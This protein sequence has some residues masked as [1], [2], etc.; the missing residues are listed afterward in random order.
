M[1]KQAQSVDES[2]V[3]LSEHVP[4]EEVAQRV[5]DSQED[6]F[7]GTLPLDL[8]WRI[9][10]DNALSYHDKW[11]LARSCKLFHSLVRDDLV[12]KSDAYSYG[13]IPFGLLEASIFKSYKPNLA[14]LCDFFQSRPGLV[15]T[16]HLDYQLEWPLVALLGMEEALEDLLEHNPQEKDANGLD[17]LDY[18]A[19]GGHAKL[20]Q[21]W[22]QKHY[23]VLTWQDR[24]DL[25]RLAIE[26]GHEELIQ[27]LREQ[28][29]YPLHWQE[30]GVP[31]SAFIWVLS[32][33][34]KSLLEKLY[35]EFPEI[36]ENPY[37]YGCL[38]VLAARVKQWEYC[39]GLIELEYE[40]SE[41][42][43]RQLVCYAARDDHQRFV[44]LL[45]ACEGVNGLNLKCKDGSA[46]ALACKG[47]QIQTVDYL[48]DNN[49]A[50]SRGSAAEPDDPSC[51]GMFFASGAGQ[52]ATVRHLREKFGHDRNWWV[53]S[54]QKMLVEAAGHGNWGKYL[55][56]LD[57]CL[58]SVSAT[59]HCLPETLRN[60]IVWDFH[61]AV[62]D[63]HLY[64]AQQFIRTFGDCLRGHAG[65]VCLRDAETASDSAI[66]RRWAKEQVDFSKLGRDDASAEQVGINEY[67]PPSTNM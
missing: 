52:V 6:S 49:L 7:L 42:E 46:Y 25:L 63:G 45:A 29:H 44:T 2:Q 18:L 11:Q 21:R 8:R 65:E 60:A 64:F 4:L 62:R 38:P 59:R 10:V 51:G 27:L 23:P 15:S 5:I 24:L 37:Q 22:I 50:S 35:E 9:S 56:L 32:S 43:K 19:M 28:Y 17:A 33:C 39:D 53:K 36:D 13:V 40:L 31:H 14:W 3:V 12:K 16:L 48:L 58:V 34:D 26:W 54:Y 57:M 1:N 61:S 66:M 47:G 55:V 30:E 41:S 67:T 20:F